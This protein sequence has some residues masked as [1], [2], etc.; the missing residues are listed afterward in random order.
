MKTDSKKE[1]I[2]TIFSS[3]IIALLTIVMGILNIQKEVKQVFIN[4]PDLDNVNFIDYFGLKNGKIFNYD[5]YE[6]EATNDKKE[7]YV[8]KHTK[9]TIKVMDEIKINNGSLFIL[10]NDIFNPSSQKEKQ[11]ILIVSNH[12]YQVIPEQIMEYISATKNKSIVEYPAE[13]LF[14]LPFYNG[15]QFSDDMT[16]FFRGDNKYIYYVQKEGSSNYYDGQKMIE[17]PRY[18]VYYIS[19]PDTEYY[20]FIPYVGISRINYH[21]NGTEI[22]RNI[23]LSEVEEP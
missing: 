13:K 7:G 12:V 17:L 11:G 1:I 19:G 9:I 22:E 15:K 14:D 2:V 3:A 10:D 21:H 6:K 4:S 23:Y 8:E 20:E 16:Q 5:V 18:K